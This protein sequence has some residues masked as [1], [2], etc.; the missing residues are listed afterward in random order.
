MDDPA[1]DKG[2]SDKASPEDHKAFED[3]TRQRFQAMLASR[4]GLQVHTATEERSVLALTVAPGGPHFMPP[5]HSFPGFGFHN[6]SMSHKRQIQGENIS[7]AEFAERMGFVT[8]HL[9]L[10]RTEL[11]GRY[12]FTMDYAREDDPEPDASL[13]P[14]P[15]ALHEQLGL[16]LK[17]AKGP[18][19]VYHV[20]HVAAP[21]PN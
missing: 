15:V 7:M 12:D 5:Q 14:L 4:F 8:N 17:Q 13:A 11:A 10:D 9:V 1:V 3:L 16:L 6:R 19:T 20:D 21:S 18:V 2:G